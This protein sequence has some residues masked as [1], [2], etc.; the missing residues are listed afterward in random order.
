[1]LSGTRSHG[2][3]FDVIWI[4]IRSA[5]EEAEDHLLVFIYEDPSNEQQTMKMRHR[6][7]YSTVRG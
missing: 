5:C 6:E 3:T 7:L 1:M 4:N 2:Q